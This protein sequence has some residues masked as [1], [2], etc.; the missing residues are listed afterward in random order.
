MIIFNVH[1]LGDIVESKLALALALAQA[2][3]NDA[4]INI[5]VFKVRIEPNCKM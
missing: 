3:Q 5:S 4:A 1:R 2:I